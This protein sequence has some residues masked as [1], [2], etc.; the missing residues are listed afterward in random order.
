M[1]GNPSD[2]G[3]VDENGVR[4]DHAQ[5]VQFLFEKMDLNK[6]G[7]VTLDEFIAVCTKDEH[8]AQLLVMG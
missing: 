6:D 7:H 3:E 2:S 4:V 1:L 5:K 8:L